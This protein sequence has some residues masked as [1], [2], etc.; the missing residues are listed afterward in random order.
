MNPL[1]TIR[2]YLNALDPR[3]WPLAIAIA[4]VTDG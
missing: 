3:L 1:H 2:D 4:G